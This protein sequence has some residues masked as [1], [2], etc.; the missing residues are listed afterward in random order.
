M[1]GTTSIIDYAIQTK[2]RSLAAALDAW[3]QKAAG[4]ACIDYGFHMTITDLTDPA[5]NEIPEIVEAGVPSFKLLMAYKG[6]LQVDD[7]TFFRALRKARGRFGGLDL[8]SSAMYRCI[9]S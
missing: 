4:K 1:G 8:P 2:G 9:Y 6:A 7:A 3:Q 5:E